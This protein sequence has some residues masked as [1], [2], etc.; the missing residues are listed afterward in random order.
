MTDNSG[1]FEEDCADPDCPWHGTIA[2]ATIEAEKAAG[3]WKRVSVDRAI[4][5]TREAGQSGP[6]E[7]SN[8]G[9]YHDCP[10]GAGG[11][12]ICFDLKCKPKDYDEP[13]RTGGA[14]HGSV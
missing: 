9:H 13:P 11:K 10:Y 7:Q 6:G 12:H 4:E 1:A 8:E 3:L 14:F 2:R 5:I